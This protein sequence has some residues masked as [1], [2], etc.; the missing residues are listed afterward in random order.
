MLKNKIVIITGASRGIG[1]SAAILFANN[2]AKVIANYNLSEKSAAEINN[3]INIDAPRVEIFQADVKSEDDVNN[4]I[5]FSFQKFGKIDVIINNAGVLTDSLLMMTPT[6][7]YQ[8]IMDVNLKGVFLCSRKVAKIMMKQRYGKIINVSSIVGRYGNS[9]QSVYAA[10]KAGIIGFSYSLA[11]ELGMYGITVNV[12]APGIIE[13]DMSA[14]LSREIKESL[15]SNVA[16]NRIGKVE[17]VAKVLLFLASDL[18]DYV[19]G[20][21]IGVD[22]CQIL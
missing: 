22:G 12:V 8:N 16:L 17:D 19:S 7:S 3:L 6:S 11:K 21:I 14:H 13:T 10:S 5:N 20:Q 9:G 1:K 2:R 15:I 4:L 18:S